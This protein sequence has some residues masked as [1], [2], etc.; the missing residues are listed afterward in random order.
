LLCL[1]PSL[2]FAQEPAPSVVTPDPSLTTPVA[3][4]TSEGPASDNQLAA[5]EKVTNDIVRSEIQ[6][7]RFATTLHATWLKPSRW[8]SWR[9]FGYK[10]AGSGLTHAGMILIAS[11]R[12]KYKNN[13]SAAPRNFLRSGHIVNLTAAS[14]VIA[15]T[16]YESALDR[17]AERRH[18]KKGLDLKTALKDFFTL[19][20]NLDA[21][22]EKRKAMIATCTTLT[23]SQREI[24]E[25]DGLVLKD[26]RDLAA[27]EFRYSYC[28][29]A[30]LRTARDIASAATI[31]GAA[32]AEFSGSMQSLLS[33]ADR[34]PKQTGVAGIGFATS[35]A[36]VIASPML[37]DWGG[38]YAKGRAQ[39]KL[40]DA[41][42]GAHEIAADKFDEHR[43]KLDQ[44]ISK[45]DP[46]DVQL[47]Q[48]LNARHSVY[49]L[50]NGIFDARDESRAALKRRSQKEL[51]ERMFFSSIVG[52]CQL[53]RGT[54]LCVAGFKYY[55]EPTKAFPLVASSGAT[56]IVGTGVWNVD[57]IQGK[58]REERA[59][60]KPAT[61]SVHASLM[62]DLD[63]LED[64]ENQMSIF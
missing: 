5:I 52:G 14:I 55:D 33:V 62:A 61:L 50:H 48:A 40:D 32:T 35:G 45:A 44:L 27:A 38:K 23:P 47:L 20:T 25:V 16:L 15:G 22:L 60:R 24:L 41:G 18:G 64:A 19:Q 63:D 51:K 4:V 11:S 42:I 46:A 12:F 1:C 7:L 54:Q 2:A 59:K 6:M 56:Y 10:M 3:P 29:I 21:L 39:S 9:V 37:I 8:K 34:N 26:L 31:F 17:L 28:D 43:Q 57:N 30:R 53:A 58:V 36:S 13:P 49:D